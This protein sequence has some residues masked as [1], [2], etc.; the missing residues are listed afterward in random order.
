MELNEYQDKAMVCAI[1]QDVQ[2]PPELTGL[3]YTVLGLTNEAGEVAGKLKKFIRDDKCVVSPEFIKKITDE[4]GDVMWYLAAVSKELNTKLD[5][6][7]QSNIDKL[8][9]RKDRGV[10]GG[11]GDNR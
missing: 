6:V 7:A 1:Y 2:I 10:L 3:F 9:D 8:Y 11:S 5:D 4:L